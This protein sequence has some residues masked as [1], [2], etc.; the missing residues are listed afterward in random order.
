MH[1]H[2]Y[3]HD[4]H[5]HTIMTFIAYP[6]YIYPLKEVLAVKSEDKSA[7]LKSLLIVS[8]ICYVSEG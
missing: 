7:K 2:T 1:I 8:Y 3:L 6:Q 5:T 4:I